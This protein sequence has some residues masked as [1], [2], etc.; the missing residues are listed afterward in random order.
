MSTE[1]LA[2]LALL[3]EFWVSF[4]P[5]LLL[6]PTP[7]DQRRLTTTSSLLFPPFLRLLT[8]TSRPSTSRAIP[9]R[10]RWGRRTSARLCLR[11]HKSSRSTRRTF[12]RHEENGRTCRSNHGHTCND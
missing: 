12:G 5:S 3:E 4:L 2:A 7:D 10:R 8:R 6:P 1:E 9:F 11:C